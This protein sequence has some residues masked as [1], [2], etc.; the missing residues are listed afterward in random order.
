MPIL[1]IIILNYNSGQYLSKCLDSIYA[2]S[3]DTRYF[4][5]IVVDNNSTDKSFIFNKKLPNLKIFSR[6]VNDGFSAGNNYGLK[7]ISKQSEY[8]FFLNPDTILE[9]DVLVNTIETFEKNKNIDAISPNIVLKKTNKLQPE[10]H[11]GFP[12]PLRSLL[13]FLN[14]SHSGYFLSYLDTTKPHQIESG[15][16]AALIIK[17]SVGDKIGW[18]DED[19]FMYGEDLQLCWDLYINNFKLYFIPNIKLTHFQ[20]V[21]SGIKKHT[22]SLASLQTKKRSILSSTQA[23]RIFHQK[24]FSKK[25]PQ[26]INHLV[27]MAINVLEKK[28][29]ANLTT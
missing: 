15:V 6:N 1:S 16:G 27:Y 23:M 3:L 8:V 13:H 12:T 14:I 4:E 18:W 7:K 28:R 9:K 11:R 29:L 22:S 20:G 5:T 17:K 10:A 26:F 24:N 19:Y 2:S 21:S 25:Y